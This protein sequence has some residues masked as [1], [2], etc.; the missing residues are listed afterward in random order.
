[1]FVRLKL[2]DDS[3]SFVTTS[4]ISGVPMIPKFVGGGLSILSPVTLTFSRARSLNNQTESTLPQSTY[5]ISSNLKSPTRGNVYSPP[6]QN[7]LP[8]L[9]VNTSR[10]YSRITVDHLSPLR[11]RFERP[12][13]SNPTVEDN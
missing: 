7:T 12:S 9:E 2:V 10:P 6:A 5:I 11:N 13:F 3:V 4:E 1:M 8:T